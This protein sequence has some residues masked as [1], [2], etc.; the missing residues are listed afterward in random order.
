MCGA[1]EISRGKVVWEAEKK[2]TASGVEWSGSSRGLAMAMAMASGWRVDGE[3]QHS[4]N[5]MAKRERER[6]RE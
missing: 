3:C 4:G 5:G 6:Q 2:R 1:D